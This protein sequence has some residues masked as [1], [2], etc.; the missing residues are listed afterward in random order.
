MDPPEDLTLVTTGT[1]AL[2]LVLVSTVEKVQESFFVVTVRTLE[3]S[4][5]NLVALQYAIVLVEVK[6]TYLK[7]VGISA[8]PRTV[9]APPPGIWIDISRY[10]GWFDRFRQ[11]HTKPFSPAGNGADIR[12]IAASEFVAEKDI[13]ATNSVISDAKRFMVSPPCVFFL[14]LCHELCVMN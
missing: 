12:W 11:P 10:I 3:K 7:S 1:C 2:G 13:T 4:L 5:L 8:G 9:E 6:S 14:Y